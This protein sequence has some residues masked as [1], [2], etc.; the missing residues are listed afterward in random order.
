MESRRATARDTTTAQPNSTTQARTQRAT[1]AQQRSDG[2]KKLADFATLP[3]HNQMRSADSEWC[4]LKIINSDLT[5]LRLH[6]VKR[7]HASARRQ[8][9]SSILTV[10]H[11]HKDDQQ[12]VSIRRSRRW[13]T[14]QSSL[15]SH[16]D[17]CVRGNI[18]K[19][20][21]TG[22]SESNHQIAGFLP[23]DGR[24]TLSVS[25]YLLISRFGGVK[26]CV[27]PLDRTWETKTRP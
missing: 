23:C 15:M 22:E 14:P 4:K 26:S 24:I 11:R 8:N 1:A 12:H 20:L 3:R 10:Q 19:A 21:R 2:P 17:V 7:I 16:I 18:R 6:D 5:F 13:N 27:A 25:V 9:V